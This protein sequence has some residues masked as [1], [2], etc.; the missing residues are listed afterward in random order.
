MTDSIDVT[1]QL[2][3]YLKVD[4]VPLNTTTVT[5]IVKGGIKDLLEN[6]A[7]ENNIIESI[8]EAK[9]SKIKNPYTIQE[10]VFLKIR[11]NLIRLNLKGNENEY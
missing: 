10:D 6:L 9:I 1:S 7:K 2:A 11:L 5:R 4:V 8:V 3:D